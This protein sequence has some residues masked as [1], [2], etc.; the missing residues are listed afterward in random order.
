MYIVLNMKLNFIITI[1]CLSL[2]VTFS[3]CAAAIA[4]GAAVGGVAILGGTA[5]NKLKSKYNG[6]DDRV[7][8]LEAR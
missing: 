3:G 5:Y 4:T 7:S 1:L 8:V 6:L 2:S